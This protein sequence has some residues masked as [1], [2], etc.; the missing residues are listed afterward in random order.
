MHWAPL[1][2]SRKHGSH[3]GGSLSVG[4]SRVRQGMW[5]AAIGGLLG[6][7]CSF[8]LPARTVC[9]T[10]DCTGDMGTGDMAKDPADPNLAGSYKVAVV[11]INP[12]QPPLGI[13]RL[14]LPS[15]EG[16]TLST[17]LPKYPFVLL[18]PAQYLDVQ[19]LAPYAQ[20]LAS[21]GIVTLVY[22]PLAE[23]D[24]SAYRQVGLDLITY[25]L[26]GT[27]PAVTGRLDGTHIGLAGY[28]L[29]AQISVAIANMVP[30]AQA[31]RGLFLLDPQVVAALQNPINATDEM[32][33]VRLAGSQPVLIIGEQ[34]GKAAV[35]GQPPC[36]P[37]ATNYEQYQSA[38][39]TGTIVLNFNNASYSDF[40]DSIPVTCQ[41]GSMAK[42]ETQR[43][44]IKF[45]AAYFQWSLLER[46]AAQT[47]LTGAGFDA[48]ARQYTINRTIK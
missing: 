31:V 35:T 14:Y 3:R 22:R 21:H 5:A 19:Q 17:R 47:Y 33:K 48:D 32:S 2:G 37:P 7:G 15:D 36:T 16:T 42:A 44:A 38:S 45:M 46:T 43:L 20:R 9:T 39:P 10:A 27:E 29:G 40:V 30:Q 12:A 28:E 23:S 4:R 41:S 6:S 34:V 11:N 8:N 18:A 1:G 24:Q 13:G 25:L 26:S